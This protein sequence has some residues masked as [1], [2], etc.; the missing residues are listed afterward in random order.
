[1]NRLFWCVWFLL[2][3][4]GVAG[5]MQQKWFISDPKIDPE[6]SRD[7]L[8]EIDNADFLR[9]MNMSAKYPKGIL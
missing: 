4:G 2:L 1:M 9:I 6:R 8:L 3:S 7:L 5:Q